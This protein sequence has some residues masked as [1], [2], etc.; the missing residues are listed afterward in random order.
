MKSS[1]LLFL[2]LFGYCCLHAQTYL[3]NGSGQ[4]VQNTITACDSISVQISGTFNDGCGYFPPNSTQTIVSGSTLYFYTPVRNF[5]CDSGWVCIMALVPVSVVKSYPAALVGNG[6]YTVKVIFDNQCM[7]QSNRDTVLAGTAIVNS[8]V[9]NTQL[10]VSAPPSPQIGSAL[11]YQI[12]TNVPTNFTSRWYRN[13]VLAYSA[14]NGLVWNTTLQTV[15]DSVKVKIEADTNCVDPGTVWS[16]SVTVTASP[17]G[18]ATED[19]DQLSIFYDP[20]TACAQVYG[21]RENSP[22]SLYSTQGQ[23]LQR[24][25]LGKALGQYIS[26]ASFGQGLYLLEV[27]HAQQ[28]K[29][30][31]IMR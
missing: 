5:G 23:L 16:N 29:V 17:T 9:A 13:N 12:T 30:V 26:L 14:P 8:M 15:Q 3:Y 10:S 18:M 4:L 11:S 25:T 7:G 19:G 24:G 21:I 1:F 6:S 2:L 22:Y 20:Q 27:Y 28:R 31:K